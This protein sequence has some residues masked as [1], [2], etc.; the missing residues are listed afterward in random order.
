MFL[1]RKSKGFWNSLR[2]M[3]AACLKIDKASRKGW[4]SVVLY[5]GE[6]RGIPPKTAYR[7]G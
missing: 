6:L 1:A 5:S 2:A 7:I 3:R 4:L